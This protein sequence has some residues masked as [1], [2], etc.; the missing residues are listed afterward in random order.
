MGTIFSITGNETSV[1]RNLFLRLRGFFTAVRLD[2]L[3]HVAKLDIK[4]CLIFTALLEYKTKIEPFYLITRELFYIEND[5][6]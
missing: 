1:L 5:R 3:F 2:R 4:K 6:K